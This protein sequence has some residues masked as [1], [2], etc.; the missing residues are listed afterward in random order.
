[1][2]KFKIFKNNK[3][4]ILTILKIN[5]IFKITLIIYRSIYKQ[6][7][8]INS[9][10]LNKIFNK[11]IKSQILFRK[12]LN[13]QPIKE[14]RDSSNNLRKSKKKIL[15][16]QKKTKI[17]IIIIIISLYQHIKIMFTNHN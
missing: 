7:L 11:L 13:Y 3:I 2:D 12:F 14:N 4:L 1:M 10:I 16:L 8:I 5:K 6:M 17:S 9:K 15:Q